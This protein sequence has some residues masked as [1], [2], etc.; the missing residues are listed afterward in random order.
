MA[1]HGIESF[2][3]IEGKPAILA[4]MRRTDILIFCTEEEKKSGC[5]K[6]GESMPGV[7]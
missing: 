1:W 2:S 7:P 3:K 4:D 6:I 5:R